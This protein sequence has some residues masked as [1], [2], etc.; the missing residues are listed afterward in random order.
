MILLS[1]VMLTPLHAWAIPAGRVDRYRVES[2]WDSQNGKAAYRYELRMRSGPVDPERPQG[3]PVRAEIRDLRSTF[4]G[5]EAPRVAVA[6]VLGLMFPKHGAPIGLTAA[7]GLATFSLPLLGWYLPERLGPAAT[8]AVE[9]LKLDNGAT[10]SGTGKL[11]IIGRGLGRVTIRLGLG[12]QLRYQ[13]V[14]D[15]RLGA[16]QVL[17][18]EGSLTDEN[19]TLSFRFR[20]Q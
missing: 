15:F 9:D 8:F 5:T 17:K 11:E 18:S 14:T 2:D 10:F 20:R 6:G 3:L 7:G 16:G 13:A 12:K 1:S 19:G 4:D